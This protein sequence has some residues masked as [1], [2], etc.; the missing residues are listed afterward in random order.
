[1]TQ[2]I[3]REQRSLW[4]KRYHVCSL[5]SSN[6]RTAMKTSRVLK[7]ILCHLQQTTIHHWKCSWALI[8][9]EYLTVGQQV[10]M[11]L[12]WLIGARWS[13]IPKDYNVRWAR[14]QSIVREKP[15]TR[16]CAWAGARGTNKLHER[17]PRTPRSLCHCTAWHL[18]LGAH[19]WP[20]GGLAMTS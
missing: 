5:A 12:E 3:P 9:S 1:M 15:Y 18:F 10:T 13:Q 4:K 6:R 20:H 7:A 14:Q 8:Q 11:C 17:C 16:D 2:Q 19:L